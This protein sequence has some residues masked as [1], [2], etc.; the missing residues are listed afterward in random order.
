MTNA[1]PGPGRPPIPR[2][3]VL[4]RLTPEMF[5]ELKA[6]ADQDDLSVP[7]MA[8]NFVIQGVRRRRLDG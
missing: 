7:V 4:L 2:K 6:I 8:R 1:K 5:E 3:T